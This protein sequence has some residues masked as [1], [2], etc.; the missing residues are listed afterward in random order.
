M[1]VH[2]CTHHKRNTMDAQWELLRERH[3]SAMEASWEH[4]ENASTIV[5]RPSE[6]PASLGDIIV[7][8][9]VASGYST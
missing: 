2:W 1:G 6:F 7:E 3:G 4:H 5:K 9:L 8:A